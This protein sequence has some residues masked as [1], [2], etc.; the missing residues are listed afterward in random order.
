MSHDFTRIYTQYNTPDNNL[1]VVGSYQKL[2]ENS[3]EELLAYLHDDVICREEGW[4]ERVIKEF[5]DPN[6]GVCGFGGALQHGDPS[7]YKTPY[8]L[9]QLRRS[10]YRSNVD[11]AEIHGERFTGSCEVAV[12]DGFALVVRRE[13]L[14]RMG[15]WKVIA[16]GCDFYCY[17]YAI[18]AM[19]HRF[20]YRVRMVGIRCHHRGGGTSVINKGLSATSQEA[21]DLSHKWY[22]E[23]FRD[24]MPWR[25]K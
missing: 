11:D 2:Y 14:D 17:D 8:Q 12:L 20:G 6:V 24:V 10:S 15:G 19:A 9:Q 25:C 5:E 7:I 3:D 13:F 4:N 18:C 21:Y 1:G 23:E 22:Y 16:G